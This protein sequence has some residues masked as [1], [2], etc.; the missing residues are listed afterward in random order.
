MILIKTEYDKIIGGYTSI[1]WN[2]ENKATADLSLSSFLFLLTNNHKM[3]LKN[4]E[5]A[6]YGSP[7][8]NDQINK[9]H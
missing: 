7:D 5:N 2:S 1:A 3:T 4:K 8:N 9:N 6:I